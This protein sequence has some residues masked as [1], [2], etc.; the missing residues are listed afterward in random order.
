MVALSP[1]FEGK[2]NPAVAAAM[3]FGGADGIY[4]LGGVQAIATAA[5][6]TSFC[7]SVAVVVGPGNAFVAEP[8]RQLFGRIGIDLIAGPTEMGED[9]P[10]R[11]HC[12]DMA[13]PQHPSRTI[14]VMVSAAESK[15]FLVSR[16]RPRTSAASIPKSA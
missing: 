5:I 4:A 12:D 15:S 8:K 10:S 2:P 14:P 6:G 16:R 7:D 1:P 13:G 3:H 9:Q 11:P